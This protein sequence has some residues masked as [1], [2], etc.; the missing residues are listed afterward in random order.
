M[1]RKLIFYTLVMSLLFS[2]CTDKLAV[3][4]GNIEEG[5]PVVAKFSFKV[6]ES[7]QI[8]SRTA[9]DPEVEKTVVQLFALAF[10]SDGALSGSGPVAVDGTGYFT[11]SM[12]SGSNKTLYL[13]ANYDKGTGGL[14]D[15]EGNS[16]DLS[17]IQS[18]DE[19]K[20]VGFEHNET[21][22]NQT[23]RSLFLMVGSMSGFS[24]NI[25]GS[26]TGAQP[27]PLDR[28]SARLNFN[29][30][31]GTSETLTD[32]KFEPYYYYVDNIPVGSYLVPQETDWKA[33]QE[34]NY[35]SMSGTDHRHLDNVDPNGLNSSFTFYLME[36]RLAPRKHIAIEDQPTDGTLYSLR[37]KRD[38]GAPVQNGNGQQYEQ[39]PFTYAPEYGTYV[40]IYGRVQGKQGA[41]GDNPGS[42]VIADARFII[43]LGE[44]GSD[45]NDLTLVND[46]NTR[47]NVQY[48]YNITITGVHSMHVEVEEENE[49][50]PGIE[51]D[52]ILT[53]TGAYF[54]LDAHFNTAVFKV[55]LSQW[56]ETKTPPVSWAYS[57]PFGR[58][59]KTLDREAF[60]E[61]GTVNDE[62]AL[63][64]DLTN[65]DY[66]WIQFAINKE[67]ET[68]ATAVVPYPG[69]NAYTGS[70]NNGNGPAPA[71]GGSGANGKKLYDVNQLMNRLYEIYK[72]EK[73]KYMEKDGTV[74]VTA[75]IDE[76]LYTYD[77]T[78]AYYKAPG[79]T[80]DIDVSLWKKSINENPRW[81][82]L[83]T[84]SKFSPDGATSMANAIVVFSQRPIYTIYNAN[85][86]TT[87]WGTESIVEDT[88]FDVTG[89]D[90]DGQL[91]PDVITSGEFAS[92]PN[93]RL[94]G[95]QN[96]VYWLTEK[97]RNQQ[98]GTYI[99]YTQGLGDGENYKLVAAMKGGSLQ[100]APLVRNRDF[101]GDGIIDANEIRWYL[102]AF[103]Q[104]QGMILGKYSLPRAQLYDMEKYVTSNQVIPVH[105]ASSTYIQNGDYYPIKVWGEQE[106]ANGASNQQGA[107]EGIGNS[108]GNYYY[109][110]CMR[111]LGTQYNT[112]GTE[113]SEPEEYIRL[114]NLWG[115]LG[116][117]SKE[118]VF[119]LR[120]LDV[121]SLR[122]PFLNTILPAGLK[123][124]DQYGNSRP[125]SL[126]VVLQRDALGYRK[127]DIWRESTHT[128]TATSTLYL[129]TL[130]GIIN[131]DEG[132]YYNCPPGY[133]LPN[134]AELLIMQIYSADSRIVSQSWTDDIFIQETEEE[135][136]YLY[137]A[138]NLF[139][140]Q[141]I[142][143]YWSSRNYTSFV[144]KDGNVSLA[145]AGIG[146]GF[147]LKVRC[148]RDLTEEQ[149]NNVY[150]AE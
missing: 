10:D 134:H 57:T 100:A 124:R 14:V 94:N 52:L 88:G 120:K 76:F 69:E 89:Y 19:F 119:D 11:L 121:N 27:V 92:Y 70:S 42:D 128:P 18:L 135:K 13:V 16:V 130:R 43:H 5:V 138:K 38:E 146:G 68:S 73:E 30:T 21:N 116:E 64:T 2:G 22:R 122:S 12:S 104:L 150:W 81:L 6:D 4:D 45:A 60:N 87:A 61:D 58:S 109:Y 93:N 31:T 84:D 140:Y 143:P 67:C 24:V 86:V 41:Q 115:S 3:K 101:D 17:T 147:G 46:Y 98:W 15:E 95:Y 108:T 72:K 102:G 139:S 75:Y 32:I 9:Q 127:E 126:F 74:V 118:A 51:G 55:D 59:M 1:N 91:S 20:K 65:N 77:P 83:S 145:S 113:I 28:I 39:G 7:E 117:Y 53:Q 85:N 66:K 114:G 144:I 141:G 125:S 82:Y 80:T 33:G 110:R 78:K 105:I 54:D 48:T 36:N 47:R 23:D 71:L 63:Q 25:N 137:I 149:V 8:Q 123:E 107:E 103:G 50:R 49:V 111:N 132:R 99:D 129:N 90:L 44:T 26:V 29:I 148:V 79:R 112:A 142:S 106:G 34:D 131:G 62:K 96:S 136:G 37:E 133:R 40:V 56:S 97:R 35:S